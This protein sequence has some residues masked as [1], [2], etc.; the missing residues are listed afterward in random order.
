MKYDAITLD[1][2]TIERKGFSFET[3][4]LGQ[5]SQ[6]KEGN[7]QFILSEI[8]VREVI[9]HMTRSANEQR[10]QLKTALQKSAKLGLIAQDQSENAEALKDGLVEPKVA[11][12]Q[13]LANFIE[14]TG[15]TIVPAEH[16]DMKQLVEH[17]FGTLAPFE[18]TGKKKSEF[19][20]AI[21]LLSMERWGQE[22]NKRILAISD[23]GGWSDFAK[24][25]EWIDVETD[26][27]KALEMFQAL[28]VEAHK[29]IVGFLSALVRGSYP[30]WYDHLEEEVFSEITQMTPYGEA[31]SHL[32][33]EVYEVE[34]EPK[35]FTLIDDDEGGLVHVVRVGKDRITASILVDVEFEASGSADF[36]VYDSEDKDYVPMGGNSCRT[37]VKKTVPILVEFLLRHDD[38]EEP[39]EIGKVEFVEQI[40][41]VDFGYIDPDWRDE[42]D[43]YER[44]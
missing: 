15:A 14:A 37:T 24:N 12:R 1:T 9:K 21:A 34:L 17:Y 30:D 11:V 27:A 8:V 4:L 20:D 16:A 7:A 38:E 23:D 41:D 19:P 13:R 33:V 35:E 36:A 29:T 6:F 18:D 22:N 44:F 3:G 25:S 26:L 40:E 31:D 10:D 43:E 32:Y 2:N 28:A 42:H 39:F 5:L